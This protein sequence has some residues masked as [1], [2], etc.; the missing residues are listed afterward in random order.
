MVRAATGIIRTVAGTGNFGN[1]C[2]GQFYGDGGP[3]TA[4]GLFQ[5]SRIVF[6]AAG[7]LVFSDTYNHRIRRIAAAT[8]IITTI[9]GSGPCCGAV[10]SFSGDGGPA[11]S[12]RFHIPYGLAV[13]G[14]GNLFVAD[15]CNHRIRRISA[16]TSIITTVAGS[17]PGSPGGCQPGGYSG[18]GGPAVL[19]RLSSPYGVAV[20]RGSL[21]I[22]DFDNDRVRRVGPGGIIT[23]VVGHG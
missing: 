20:H 7:N 10:G 22:G 9:A 3:A 16:T 19:A 11:T 6:D 23:T 8:G 12:A 14:A 17:G 2:N 18:D 13:D 5:P 4:A 15:A 1:C 21:Y